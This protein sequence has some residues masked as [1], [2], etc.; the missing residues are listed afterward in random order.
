M[1]TP[2]MTPDDFRRVGRE[3]VEFIA[4]Y[5]ET[6]DRL[7]VNPSATGAI[8]PGDVARQF[9]THGPESPGSPGEWD[10]IL[11]D[12]QDNVM[13]GLTHWQSPQ[14]YGYFPC[15]V[16]APAVL[17]ELLSAGLGQQGMLWSTSPACTEVETVIVGWMARLLALPAPM[18]PG[19]AGGGVILGT[20][21]E[22]TLT[23]MVAAR[24][25]ARRSLRTAGDPRA[26]NPHFTLY[27]STQAHSS[28]I[29]AAMVAG[30]AD[31]PD[32]R[33]H[34]RLIDVDDR[35]RMRADL[36]AAAIRDD[37]AAGRVPFFVSA[38]MGT[39]GTT[40]CDPLQE[41]AQACSGVAQACSLSSPRSGERSTGDP[42]LR[43]W[44]HCDAAHSGACLICP[45]LRWMSVGLDR[46]DSF[47]FNPHKWLLTN[48]DCDLFYVA[49]RRW[50]TDALSITPEYL[51]NPASDAGAVIDYRDWQVP[52]G[53][54]FRA[55][56]L[57][58]VL[59][60]YGADGLRAHVREHVRLAALL[61]GWVRQDSRF[62]LMAE[63]TCNLLCFRLRGDDAL[64]RRLMDRLNASGRMFLSHT[65]IESTGQKRLV[66]R[67]A[68]GATT[69]REEHVRAA[70]GWIVEEAQRLVPSR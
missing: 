52:L 17:G 40:A 27:T 12:V 56:K 38:T 69:T 28:V 44:L 64:S 68:I 61:E 15:N 43:P 8:S 7:P 66:L 48:F 41:V 46:F 57:W 36:L 16:S 4:R 47:C 59:R 35:Q 2:H 10:R 53:R 25:R 23:A 42:H 30:L 21:S 5:W 49:D 60:Q 14:F 45:E 58:F 18:S 62:E 20:A 33:T 63:R 29:K 19:G 6:V 26:A 32:D 55:L 37:T 1:T 24:D 67:M 3:M 34:L 9:P 31:G 70:W 13:P 54:R 65:V 22:A 51:R 11:A 39:T 50:L